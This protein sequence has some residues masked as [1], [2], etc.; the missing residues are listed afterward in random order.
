VA[1]NWLPLAH[2]G[3]P[4]DIHLRAVALGRQ[5]PYIPRAAVVGTP[6]PWLRLLHRY[7]ATYSAAPTFA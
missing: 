5:P 7:R 4:S 6:L 2:I 3:T 1:L